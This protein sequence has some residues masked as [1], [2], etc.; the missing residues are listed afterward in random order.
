MNKYYWKTKNDIHIYILVSLNTTFSIL[1]NNQ[2]QSYRFQIHCFQITN[3]K[4]KKSHMTLYYHIQIQKSFS[5]SSELL[6]SQDRH[7]NSWSSSVVHVNCISIM[8]NQDVNT[9]LPASNKIL[10][11]KKS[12]VFFIPLTL[13]WFIERPYRV[14]F[15]RVCFLGWA[16]PQQ[17][18]CQDAKPDYA[19]SRCNISMQIVA[20]AVFKCLTQHLNG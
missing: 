1:T 9:Q 7:K 2:C 20:I 13:L 5:Q 17:N 3:K 10:L 14:K 4:S 8:V 12:T 16:R 6:E 15:Q 18:K 19:R 11:R